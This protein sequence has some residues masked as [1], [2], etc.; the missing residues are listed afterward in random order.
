MGDFLAEEKRNAA[1][2]HL[3]SI[4]GTKNQDGALGKRWYEESYS[5]GHFITCS[6]IW[7]DQIPVATTQTEADQA[8]TNNPAVIEKHTLFTLTLD[9]TSNGTVWIAH[10]TPGDTSSPILGDWLLPQKFGQ[11]YTLRIY[12]NNNNEISTTEMEGWI[13]DYLNGFLILGNGLSASSQGYTEPLKITGYRYIGSRLCSTSTCST[14]GHDEDFTNQTSFTVTHN[15]NS[16]DIIV[17]VFDDSGNK[18]NPDTIHIIDNNSISIS[19]TS[20]TSGS[21]EIIT[22]TSGSSNYY[23]HNQTSS[24]TSWN[25]VHNL[26][27]TDLLVNIFNAS[28]DRIIPDNINLTDANNLTIS[29]N[30]A[31]DGKAVI[32]AKDTSSDAFYSEEVTTSST[33][34]NITHNLNSQELVI[35]VWDSSDNRIYPDQVHIVDDN[36]IQLTFTTATSGK[37]VIA[38]TSCTGG[39][40]TQLGHGTQASIK[41]H[42]DVDNNMVPNNGDV[43]TYNTS[44]GLWTSEP[45]PSSGSLQR[46]YYESWASYENTY[47]LTLNEFRNNSDRTSGWILRSL[48]SGGLDYW[49]SEYGA[50]CKF[51]V[52]DFTAHTITDN[53]SFATPSDFVDWKNTNIPN[54]GIT[55]DNIVVLRMY[56]EV[57]TSIPVISKLYGINRIFLFYKASGN[58]YK[59]LK[60]FSEQWYVENGDQL[61]YNMWTS[62]NGSGPS[63]SDFT[64]TNIGSRAFWI[65]SNYHK[66]YGCIRN[67]ETMPP[68]GARTA[69]NTSTSSWTTSPGTMMMVTSSSRRL[70]YDVSTRT[71]QIQYGIDSNT[72]ILEVL[73][74]PNKSAL[75]F[76]RMRGYSNTNERAVY[77]SPIGIDDLYIDAFDT[78]LY[79]L[80]A[81]YITS[82]QQI[83][84]QKVNPDSNR[85]SV[86][87]NSFCIPRSEW[88][89]DRAIS[90][91]VEPMRK[92]NSFQFPRIYFRL[93]DKS[94]N[95]VGSL[96][97]SYITLI[98][99]SNY[100]PWQLLVQGGPGRPN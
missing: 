38:K 49:S 9:P 8:V 46:I 32:I 65:A 6:D 47:P 31:T 12:D 96:T 21:V 33:T 60:C 23:V 13:F 63:Q 82:G 57:D 79:D 78:T 81:V 76:A 36:S 37:V 89:N 11:G 17:N 7:M 22:P 68:S 45:P 19:F 72:F 70:L 20:S 56:D 40:S 1:F 73:K 35:N 64:A 94:T 30:T 26:N 69:W 75:Y 88:L 3:Y 53:L 27:S 52:D 71:W 62:A 85:Q 34:W 97:K 15:L 41:D 50:K 24:L 10:E 91:F 95:R 59:K 16:T 5:T 51:Q 48:N 92:T 98:K 99:K 25:V 77:V 2:K 80:E 14:S 44:S 4:A 100:K 43:L 93:R 18:I 39:S 86:H 28:S 84:F 61:L 67:N 55:F 90:Q 29:F 74:D 54:N 42:I 87:R 58:Y 66:M 83:F